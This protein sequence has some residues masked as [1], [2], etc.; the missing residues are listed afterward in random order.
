[1]EMNA[2]LSD[3]ARR[4]IFLI[5]K[6]RQGDQRA[7]TELVNIYYQSLY[8][9]VLKI[10]KHAEDA[11][12]VTLSSFEKAFKNLEKYDDAYA[13]STWLFK[14][15]SNLSIDLLRKKKIDTVSLDLH[16]AYTPEKGAGAVPSAGDSDPEEVYIRAQRADIMNKIVASLDEASRNLVELRY[17]KE[18]SYE[19]IADELKMPLGTVKVQLHRVKKVLFGRL[20]SSRKAY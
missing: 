17:F 8:H 6:A 14:I 3:K 18:F 15:A 19:E 1:M 20:S 9:M 4:D 5:E 2:H 12:D 16:I 13:F 10:V 7:Y 11:E